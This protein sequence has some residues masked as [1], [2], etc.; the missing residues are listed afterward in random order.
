MSGGIVAREKATP[1][2]T[3]VQEGAAKEPAVRGSRL[4]VSAV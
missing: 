1:A 3:F 2:K 4:E